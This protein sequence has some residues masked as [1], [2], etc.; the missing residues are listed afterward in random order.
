M[1]SWGVATRH[2]PTPSVARGATRYQRVVL[3]GRLVMVLVALVSVLNTVIVLITVI[4]ASAWPP[5]WKRR[6][7]RRRR[8]WTRVM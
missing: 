1:G 3:G 5:W 4:R 8:R 2:S 7:K 6:R